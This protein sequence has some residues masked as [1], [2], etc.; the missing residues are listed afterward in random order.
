M[1]E[2]PMTQLVKHAVSPVFHPQLSA[3]SLLVLLDLTVTRPVAPPAHHNLVR[4]G[5]LPVR[6]RLM[7]ME[8][9]MVLP[10]A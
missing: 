10:M 1:D 6:A 5:R 9:V 2:S 8:L 3:S 4:L 7:V